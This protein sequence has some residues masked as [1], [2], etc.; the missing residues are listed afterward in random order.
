MRLNKSWLI[1]NAGVKIESQE[2]ASL[3][4]VQ[5]GHRY[6]KHKVSKIQFNGQK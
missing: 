2:P 6:E 4:W 3:T 1:C 5:T